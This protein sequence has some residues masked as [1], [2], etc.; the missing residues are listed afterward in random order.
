MTKISV[1][2]PV[3]NVEKYLRE[4][5]DSVVNQT[6]RDIEI[7]CVNDGS[8]DNSLEILKEYEKQDSRIK[9]IDKK[10]EGVAI[11]RNYAIDI[12]S[13]EYILFLDAD[14]ILD[15]EGCEW[16]Y[17]ACKD[18]NADILCYD[19]KKFSK[20]PLHIGK[21]KTKKT[22][23][24]ISKNIIKSYLIYIGGKIVKRSFI[25]KYNIKFP[26][27]I[28][29]G[30]DG[31][32]CI[33][34]YFNSEKWYH[35]NIPLYYYR[36]NRNEAA[37]YNHKNAIK[38]DC[39]GFSYLLD[40]KEFQN[41]DIEH[42]QVA[43][44][45][46]FSGII[47]YYNEPKNK[48]YQWAYLKDIYIFKKK[49]KICVDNSILLRCDNYKAFNAC[50]YSNFILSNLQNIFS[51]KNDNRKTHKIITILGLKIKFKRTKK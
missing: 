32:F 8:T 23:N 37:T 5:L 39:E 22:C 42:K 34:C 15:I 17:T 25:K 3:Y 50:N 7:I 49:I 48:K 1:I 44:D 28:K 2:I 45:K 38:T 14:D 9:I 21:T 16:T 46:C 31:L 26:P 13:G 51:V 27:K 24:L 36:I 11:A 47:Y 30:E 33:K 12:A 6:L 20:T 41:A 35:L 19:L 4:C 29:T 10:N 43:L 18:N 40:S